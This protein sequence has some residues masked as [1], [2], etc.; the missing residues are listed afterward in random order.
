MLFVLDG[1]AR[2]LAAAGS[3]ARRKRGLAV[4]VQLQGRRMRA[5]SVERV[6]PAC[7]AANRSL[8]PRA[9]DLAVSSTA[10]TTTS[11][12]ENAR[13]Y[14]EHTTSCSSNYPRFADHRLCF[15][16]FRARRTRE[17]MHRSRASHCMSTPHRNQA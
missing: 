8:P 2:A 16:L 15:A 5:D 4:G 1:M 14:L 13:K 9:H 6:A 11:S 7:T 12:A 10:T 17:H 3:S